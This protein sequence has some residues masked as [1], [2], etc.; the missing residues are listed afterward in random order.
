MPASPPVE[1]LPP[2][3]EVP[4]LVD[5]P[6]VVEPPLVVAPVVVPP[7]V[8]LPPVVPGVFGVELQAARAATGTRV[9]SNFVAYIRVLRSS[10][11]LV[12]DR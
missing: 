10:K 3:L 2:V 4:P 8:S 6:P 7:V 5:E 9:I 11:A 12:S 1:L